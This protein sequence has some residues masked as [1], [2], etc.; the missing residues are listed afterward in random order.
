MISK[1]FDRTLVDVTAETVAREKLLINVIN[2][3]GLAI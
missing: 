3:T 1:A 2:V